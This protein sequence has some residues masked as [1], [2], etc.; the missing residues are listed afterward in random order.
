MS[1][2][3]TKQPR[4]KKPCRPQSRPQP[5]PQPSPSAEIPRSRWEQLTLAISFLRKEMFTHLELHG[6]SQ[7]QPLTMA[8]LALLWA[9]GTVDQ[10]L[11]HRYLAAA[12]L[13][14][15]WCGTTYVFTTYKGFMAALSTWNSELIAVVMV[16]LQ[17]KIQTLTCYKVAGR[18][19]FGID[20]TKIG[21]PWTDSTD[22]HLG[23]QTLS[24]RQRKKQKKQK[25]HTKKLQQQR[26]KK[27]RSANSQ[28]HQAV[29]PQLLLTLLWQ[30]TTGLPWSWQ[31]GP[32]SASERDHGRQLIRTLIA[33]AILVADAGFTGYELWQE[34]LAAGHDFVIRIGSNVTLLT[35]LGWKVKVRGNIAYLWPKAKQQ[36]RLKP[37]VVR[38][39]KFET[40]KSTVWLA[41]SI[42][43]PQE[44][45]DADLADI[46]KQRWGI[47][48]WFRSF[49]Q[50]FGRRTLRSR[51]AEHAVCEL[52]WSIVGLAVIQHQG[53]QALEAAGE[54]P[55]ILSEAEA[56]RAVRSTI[57]HEDFK[58]KDMPLV[59]LRLQRAVIDP[60]TRTKPK[61]GRHIHR[62]KKF[63]PVGEPKLLEATPEQISLARE[64]QA[65]KEAA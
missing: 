16:A 53:V 51:D 9:W 23:Q 33:G 20:G 63:E 65:V 43:D 39:V 44:L 58:L 3:A 48:G 14:Q 34:V 56:I 27:K 36:A 25:K 64:L 45:S 12:Q 30:M 21:V 13:V 40:A 38:L 37:I 24:K 10:T 60:Y 18:P 61:R 17:Q 6:N 49:K 2:T 46:Y 8:M 47:E 32:V 15:S 52:D 41:T 1:S 5:Q 11:A 26:A 54:S 7:W 57:M 35:K 22:R 62:K 55:D 31:T 19:L 4:V 28:A 42:L 50:T 59:V 29:R